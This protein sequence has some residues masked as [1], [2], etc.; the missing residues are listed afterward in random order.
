[1]NIPITFR[2]FSNEAYFLNLQ[3]KFA[4]YDER[5]NPNEPE[6]FSQVRTQEFHIILKTINISTFEDDYITKYFYKDFI[7]IQVDKLAKRYIDAFKID[8]ESSLIVEDEKIKRFAEIRMRKFQELKEHLTNTN[9]ILL[10]AKLKIIKQIDVVY[11]YLSHVHL[12]PQ[13]KFEDK[14]KFKWNKT[15]V[16]L[17]LLMLREKKVIDHSF[18]NEF[19]YLLDKSLLYYSKTDKEFK[20]ITDSSSVINDFKNGN[21]SVDKAIKRLKKFFTNSSFYEFPYQ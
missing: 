8:L 5:E 20:S 7:F 6:V 17:L 15:D 2:D 11:E 16:L 3:N 12:L 21:R 18:D 13:Y 9:Y 4:I 19:G 10:A 1:M 14:I